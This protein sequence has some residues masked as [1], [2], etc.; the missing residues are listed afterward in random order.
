MVNPSKIINDEFFAERYDVNEE[1][2]CREWNRHVSQ[3][4]YGTVKHKR[5]AYPAHRFMYQYKHG[6]VEDG[7][8]ICHK[9]DNRKCVNPDHL[10]LGTARANMHDMIA[11]GRKV[12][13]CG[14]RSGGSKLT[15][16]QVIAIR[17]DARPQAAI[18]ADYGISQSNVSH[19]KRNVGW[20]SVEHQD[21][22]DKRM[23]LKE[24][25]AQLGVLYMP[26][27][28]RLFHA[29]MDMWEALT[30][31]FRVHP[32]TLGYSIQIDRTML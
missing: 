8:H 10:F 15:A 5:K 14:E 16:D 20:K 22:G 24:L 7:M 18:A 2:G 19:V 13:A 9:C 27:K 1:T 25:A 28:D 26:L 30:T 29:R 32:N 6:P 17:D 3:N 31:P 4:G 11:K 12:V 23:T 21:I